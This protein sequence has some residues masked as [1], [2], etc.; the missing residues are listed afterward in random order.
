MEPKNEEEGIG[1]TNITD[2]AF[3]KVNTKE[4]FVMILI[5]VK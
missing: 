3:A 1:T 4:I 2:G 5:F